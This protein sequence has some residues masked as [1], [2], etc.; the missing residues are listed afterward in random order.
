MKKPKRPIQVRSGKWYALGHAPPTTTSRTA[1]LL[2]GQEECCDCGLVHDSTI[3]VELRNGRFHYW[4]KW[5]V[6]DKETRVA[7]RRPQKYIRRV[8]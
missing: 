3:K 6:N 8:K 1:E 2:I 5:D 7:R 4:I